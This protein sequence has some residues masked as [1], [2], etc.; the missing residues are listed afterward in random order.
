MRSRADGLTFLLRSPKVAEP[1]HML[2]QYLRTTV[3]GPRYFEL[4]ALIAAREIEQHYE[5]SGHE[6]AGL[7]AG[8]DLGR[9]SFRD[10]KVAPALWAKTVDLPA[11]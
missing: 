7:R 6:P 4:C 3:V 11:R 2:N 5:W 8:I 1:I 10:H 9:A